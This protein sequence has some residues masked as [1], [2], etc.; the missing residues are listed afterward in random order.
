MHIINCLSDISE[1]YDVI[2]C[3]I[4][5]CLHDGIT[6][7]SEAVAAIQTFKES[8]SHRVILITNSPRYGFDV[9]E[10]ILH[11]GVPDSIYDGIVSSGDA[12][13][14]LFQKNKWGHE[15]YFIGMK[16]H[17]KMFDFS[18][19]TRVP[20]SQAEFIFCSAPFEDSQ[21]SLNAYQ[22][23]IS[24]GVRAGLPFFC[25]NPDVC[26]DIGDKRYFCAGAIAK[27][28]EKSG[29][30]V[31]YFGKPHRFI[32]DCAFEKLSF[33]TGEKNRDLCGKILAIGDGADTDIRGAAQMGFDSLFIT[34]G[35]HHDIL[36]SDQGELNNAA[37]QNFWDKK[38]ISPKYVIEALR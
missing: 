13:T 8:G 34:R 18:G 31:F 3:D 16:M 29:G 36:H 21:E 2:F 23:T 20:L 15:G 9:Q 5:G 4:W 26:V 30:K 7:F 19:M 33:V 35:I 14:A 6:A 25:A 10:Q 12:F 11:L 27:E 32:Y 22:S 17:E 24:E 37:L 1:H 38:G 28:Y